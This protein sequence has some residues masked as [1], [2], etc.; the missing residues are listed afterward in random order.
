MT[1]GR[2]VALIALSFIACGGIGP[3]HDL[4]HK[5]PWL[6]GRTEARMIERCEGPMPMSDAVRCETM[7]IGENGER[8]APG[9]IFDAIE[10]SIA[11]VPELAAQYEPRN[12]TGRSKPRSTHKLFLLSVEPAVVFAVPW[13]DHPGW[14]T[15]G[16]TLRTSCAP[17]RVLPFNAYWLRENPP[18][19]PGS[20]WWSPQVPGQVTHISADA[21]QL[22]IVVSDL[23]LL[24]KA[25]GDGLWRVE[26][27]NSR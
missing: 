15:E 20:F 27:P 26:R 1:R 25:G 9:P 3:W 14:I 8:I 23:R 19:K 17:S 13:G 10:A 18:V 22:E 7:I 6:H 2:A 21:T 16:C 11:T 12:Y 24:M 5:G 4:P